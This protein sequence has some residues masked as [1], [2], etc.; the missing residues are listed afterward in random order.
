MLLGEKG[1]EEKKVLCSL[2]MLKNCT[3]FQLWRMF[4]KLT[5]MLHL[6]KKGRPRYP[7]SEEAGAQVPSFQYIF[8]AIIWCRTAGCSVEPE[9]HWPRTSPI[10]EKDCPFPARGEQSMPERRPGSQGLIC[11]FFL[12]RNSTHS[13]QN[14]MVS[15]SMPKL[16][17]IRGTSRLLFF[18]ASPVWNC[19]PHF[20]ETPSVFFGGHSSI[21]KMLDDSTCLCRYGHIPGYRQGFLFLP[22]LLVCFLRTK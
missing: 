3:Q 5:A 8:G 17:G 20:L 7:L 2:L 19:Q 12:F 11:F 1:K 4:K 6:E 22:G 16:T 14:S 10:W 9:A 21:Q 15:E 18:W 13:D